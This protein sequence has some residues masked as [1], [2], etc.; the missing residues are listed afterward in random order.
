M[1]LVDAL[2]GASNE[3]TNALNDV[4]PSGTD[5]LKVLPIPAKT[6][7]WTFSLQRQYDSGDSFV[8]KAINRIEGELIRLSSQQFSVSA[9]DVEVEEFRNAIYQTPFVKSL[10]NNT[11]T[12]SLVEGADYKVYDFLDQWVGEAVN[13]DN[14]YTF[15]NGST[16]RDVRGTV[17]P[18]INYY[19]QGRLDLLNLNA[20]VT[21]LT[22][23][24]TIRLNKMVPESIPDV[25]LDYNDEGKIVYNV[26]IS[27]ERFETEAGL[28]ENIGLGGDE[29]TAVGV[30][31]DIAGEVGSSVFS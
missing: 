2:G 18:P 11:A 20:G 31:G 14:T 22:P 24:M 4:A 15:P 26:G 27:F 29:R 8:D 21:S 3:A 30:G 13:N 23:R 12:L 5:V 19:M 17:N 10:S 7:A 6:Y 16:A 28:L 25:E 1:P 9:V